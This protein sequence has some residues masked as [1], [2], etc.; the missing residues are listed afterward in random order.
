MLLVVCVHEDRQDISRGRDIGRKA[1]FR[2]NEG[3]DECSSRRSP[4]LDSGLA[5][6]G[7]LTQ[8]MNLAVHY[9]PIGDALMRV[10]LRPAILWEFSDDEREAHE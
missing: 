10:L 9:D 8:G 6:F 5:L 4:A 1:A 3:R 2:S 7:A